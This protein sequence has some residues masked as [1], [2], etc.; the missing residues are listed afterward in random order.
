MSTSSSRNNSATIA[1]NAAAVQS[2]LRKLDSR[3][4]VDNGG[5]VSQRAEEKMIKGILD[6]G[7][8]CKRVIWSPN[9]AENAA[10]VFPSGF[11]F[12]VIGDASPVLPFLF[13]EN[14]MFGGTI[15]FPLT[16]FGAGGDTIKDSQTR[17][18]ESYILDPKNRITERIESALPD[19]ATST[20]QVSLGNG[21]NY[22]GIFEMG[23]KGEFGWE[24]SMWV[25]A[26]SHD[27][28]KS[29][30]LHDKM[31]KAMPDDMEATRAYGELLLKDRSSAKKKQVPHTTWEQFFFNDAESKGVYASQRQHR[32]NV[33]RNLMEAVG[34]TAPSAES[35]LNN[36]LCID[37]V[38]NTIETLSAKDERSNGNAVFL[39]DMIP[40]ATVDNMGV[41]I[42]ESP[43]LGPV[44]LRGP[45]DSEAMYDIGMA[46][47]PAS[48]GKL[49]SVQEQWHRLHANSNAD[50]VAAELQTLV[51]SPIH[52]WSGVTHN[53]R[54]YRGLFRQRNSQWKAIETSLGY[55]A[56]GE[57]QM[58][59]VHVKLTETTPL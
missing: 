15:A 53:I 40:I 2:A 27:P 39:S 7:P 54:M 52:K 6:Y 45:W 30:R 24:R 22:A 48:T 28:E 8:Y 16:A 50:V 33:A 25:V 34:L 18:T 44:V 20:E 29:Q 26:R 38:Y 13:P 47:F 23:K 3:Y 46:G 35:I 9:Y 21:A 43:Q 49:W 37:S 11:Q 1:K 17:L 32:A 36:D 51:R 57:I 42:N 59:P 19:T 4:V 12:E 31:K 56:S 5:L 55:Q 14:S 58:R 41:V 10:L